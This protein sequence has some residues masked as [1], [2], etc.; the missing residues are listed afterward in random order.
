MKK[1]TVWL[2]VIALVC[3]GGFFGWRYR[4]LAAFRSNLGARNNASQVRVE[5]R[6]LEVAIT[7]SGTVQA[8]L[9]KSVQAGVAGTISR[10]AAEEGDMVAAGDPLLLLTNDSVTYQVDQARLDLALATQN[11]ESL[12]G[13]AGAK[14]KAELDVKSAETNL[15]TAEDKVADLTVES[16]ISGEVWDI[17]VVEGD[18]VKVGQTIATIG[19][20]S[21]FKVEIKVKQA[22]VT[23]FRTGAAV[24]VLPGGDLPLMGGTLTSIGREGSMGSSS[25]VVEFPAIVTISKPAAGLRAGMTVNVNYTDDDG[26]TYS[27]PGTVSAQDKK[28]VTAKVDGTVSAVHVLEG[29]SVASGELLV[30]LENNSAVVSRDQARNVLESAK[31]SLFIYQ[32]NIDSQ[33]L[34]VEAAR[35][36]YRDKAEAAEKLTVRSPI[37]GKVLTSTAQVG[38]DVTA[39]QTLVTVGEVSPLVVAIPVDELDIVNVSLGQA[40]TIEV[41]ALPSE[42]F[43]GKVKKIAQEGVVQQGITNFTVTI[44]IDKDTPR[45]GMSATATIAIAQKT[46]VLTLPVEALN[47]DGSQASVYVLENGQRTQKKVKIG[48]QS[49]I[50]AEI[51]SGLNEGD[52]VVV[53]QSG[54][55]QGMGAL[56]MPNQV[57]RTNV[58]PQVPR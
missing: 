12:T 52:T 19:D 54:D 33:L 26:N 56:R 31:Q 2:L 40:A 29:D 23:A 43:T 58:S 17:A 53:G 8:N 3:V 30:S 34:K 39:N 10:V 25:K 16:P 14:A 13:P 20:T 45:I 51:I 11:L 7:G 5:R 1:K 37:S 32:S 48:V 22:D 9:K 44:E 38:D 42:T 21:A 49:D 55:Q 4:R 50:Y 15:K 41:D 18:S 36:S 27:L 46:G 28:Q 57:P 47:W 6:D 35:V 24:S